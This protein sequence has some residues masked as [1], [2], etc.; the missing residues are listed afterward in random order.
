MIAY[1]K[2]IMAFLG[3]HRKRVQRGIFL[4]FFESLFA[5]VPVAM[6]LYAFTKLANDTLTE[7]DILLVFVVMLSAVLIR[8]LLAWLIDHLMFLATYDACERQRLGIGDRFR[9]FA[10]GF[11]TRG[12]LG[13]VAAIISTDLTFIEERA[14]RDL[15]IMVTAVAMT[16]IGCVMLS[17]A[18]VRIGAIAI[19]VSGVSI[20]LAGWIEKICREES[21]LRQ[22]QQGKLTEA[23]LEYAMGI[24]VIK[25]FNIA[26]KRAK[27]AK[28][29]IRDT[30]AGS[31]RFEKRYIPPGFVYKAGFLVATALILWTSLVFYKDGTLGIEFTLVFVIFAFYV[32]LPAMNLGGAIP[33]FAVGEAGLNRY[34]ALK[35]QP[36]MG[37]DGRDIIIDN[38]EI[39]FQDVSFAYDDKTVLKNISFT[40]RPGTMTAL[41]GQSGSGKTTIANLIVRFWDVNE[42]AVTIGDTDIRQM[43]TDCL[44]ENISMVFQRV[45]LFHDTIKNNIRFGKPDATDEEIM[46]AARA[47]RCHDF[48]SA[49]P[50][51]YDTLVTEAG[52]S[53]SGGEKQRISIAR[54]ILKDAPIVLLDE[55]TASIDPDN[56]KYIQ[57][58]IGALVNNK[59]L[60]VIAHRL[61]TIR[62]ADQILVIDKGEIVERGRHEALLEKQGVYHRLWTKRITA[63][64]WKMKGNL[65]N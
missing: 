34:E 40:A 29:A 2:R 16:L 7:S 6:L 14:I 59:T 52:S 35:N 32:F 11:F 15:D 60:I 1:Y 42:G 24:S 54:A 5:N 61:S 65:V 63:R 64:S 13:R 58:A 18:D 55:A 53:L 23:I 39:G 43:T 8:I 41:V 3:R 45:Y 9:Y 27:T 44:L 56:E 12:N 19:I 47:A 21:A 26:G 4:A 49:L 10:M 30:K 48:I 36:I 50:Q 20:G 57:A 28:K 33:T 62:H 22:E 38:H 51:G 46:A 17:V 25:A 31:I 37:R